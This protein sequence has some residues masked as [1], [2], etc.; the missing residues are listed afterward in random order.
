MHVLSGCKNRKRS[1]AVMKGTSE[2]FPDCIID[3]NHWLN[4]NDCEKKERKKER[5]TE[6]HESNR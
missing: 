4:K 3:T 2:S 5:S 6:K 1:P